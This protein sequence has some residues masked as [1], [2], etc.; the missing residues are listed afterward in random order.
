MI[1]KARLE[2]IKENMQCSNPYD[3]AMDMFSSCL[4][5]EFD[6]A[7][8]VAMEIF[9]DYPS[10]DSIY[11]DVVEAHNDHQTMFHN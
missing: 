2:Y 9:S 5:Q 7:L 6:D 8:D 3:L 11:N 1:E 10:K 4:T